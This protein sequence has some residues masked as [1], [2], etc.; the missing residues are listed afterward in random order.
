[1]LAQGVAPARAAA[2]VGYGSAS[3]FG[4]AYRAAFG[5][6]PRGGRE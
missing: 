4:A 3:A 5:E 6:T 1:M 2:A